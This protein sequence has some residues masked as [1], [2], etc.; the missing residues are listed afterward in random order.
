MWQCVME[1]G[2]YLNDSALVS[3]TIDVHISHHPSICRSFHLCFYS[4]IPIPLQLEI[5]N[6]GN[7]TNK[8]KLWLLH[9]H[10]IEKIQPNDI[11]LAG[12][13][14]TT[15]SNSFT[16]KKYTM[17]WY[18]VCLRLRYLLYK[19]WLGWP[20]DCYNKLWSVINWAAGKIVFLLNFINIY[21]KRKVIEQQRANTF[22]S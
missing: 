10:R 9:K 3:Y 15:Q 8:K 7:C 22:S 21:L 4:V 1:H 18:I 13:W 11:F 20:I 14:E 2:V 16:F 12:V 5:T 17:I 19:L 6:F